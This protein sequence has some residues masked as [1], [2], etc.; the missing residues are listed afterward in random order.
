MGRC[1]LTK[2]G[3][4]RT[5]G[6]M[7]WDA[8]HSACVSRMAD[9]VAKNSNI[10]LLSGWGRIY[11]LLLFFPSRLWWATQL[12]GETL[13]WL[14][15]GLRPRPFSFV[16]LQVLFKEL[17]QQSCWF[18]LD[19]SRVSCC[20]KAS[21]LHKQLQSCSTGEL[22]AGS[23]ISFGARGEGFWGMWNAG[24]NPCTGAASVT[25]QGAETSISPGAA[26]QGTDSNEQ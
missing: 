3:A 14:C 23:A 22:G 18:D 4:E 6:R 7:F 20:A 17:S 21:E 25:V 9:P 12:C 10:C 2:G 16:W 8:A 26:E 11:L 24:T 13:V 5:W 19:S 15:E 1:R